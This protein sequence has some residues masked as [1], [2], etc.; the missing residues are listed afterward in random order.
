MPLTIDD[1]DAIAARTPDHRRPQAGRAFHRGRPGSG[2]RRRGWSCAAARGGAAEGQPDRQRPRASS[3]KRSDAQRATP[4]Q[5]V[6][7][8]GDRA[9]SPSGGFAILRGS[10][11]P[12]GCVVKLAG[13]RGGSTPA[14]RAC[15]TP[16]RRASRPCSGAR[17]SRATSSSSATKGRGAAPA[18]ARCWPSPR[19]LVGQELDDSV[20][21]ITD[22]R[23]SGATQ[24][25]MVG[26]VSP[27]AQVGGPIAFVR[28]GDR[29]HPGRRRAPHRRRRR[30]G[31]AQGRL[32]AARAALSAGRHGQVRGVRL[33]GR[34][35]CRHAARLAL[36][37]RPLPAALRARAASA[38][39]RSRR[40]A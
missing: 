35:G 31:I 2:G 29:D 14:R 39:K 32:E 36:S 28:D 18:C 13:H 10:L 8:S 26:H 7:R 15:S 12:E 17:S 23:F 20:A 9:L 6:V 38:R 5:Q 16:R 40:S 22:G 33:V 24:G 27:E 21:L 4:G 34:R 1:F 11:A 19:A 25:F 30:P 3:R 37:A